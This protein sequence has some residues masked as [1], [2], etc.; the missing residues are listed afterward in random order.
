MRCLNPLPHLSPKGGRRRQVRGED[1]PPRLHRPRVLVCRLYTRTRHKPEGIG[2]A[3]VECGLYGR[4]VALPKCLEDH[5][6]IQRIWVVVRKEPRLEVVQ[7]DE[8]V[9]NGTPCSTGVVPN[10]RRLPFW[11]WSGLN[12]Q[13]LS[14]G[15]F[16]DI[17]DLGD[18]SRPITHTEVARTLLALSVY[19]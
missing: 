3:V 2:P 9:H 14:T 8:K 19:G 11:N 17:E 6:I 7:V 13:G 1:V 18:V 10:L 5:I 15:N 12:C 16:L 4:V